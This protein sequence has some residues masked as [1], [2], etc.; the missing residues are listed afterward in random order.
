[1][2]INLSTTLPDQ[3]ATLKRV[4]AYRAPVSAPAQ[5]TAE[6]LPA[7]TTSAQGFESQGTK[8]VSESRQDLDGGYRLTR[9]YEREDGR[10]FMRV[11][12][13]AFTDRG[14]RRTVTQQNPSGSITQYEE[15]LDRES[16]G[17][18]RRTQRFRDE[19]GETATQITSEYKV[20]DPFILTG[21]HVPSDS[22][23]QSPFALL[24]GTQL[25][26]SA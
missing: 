8:L 5:K 14:A 15:V 22:F 24:R 23:Q 20:T 25:D 13:F 1:M 3:L 12:D 17:T 4:Q 11:E 2:D 6:N 26:L 9:T 19:T 10:Q 16:G 21:G 7:V 18:F